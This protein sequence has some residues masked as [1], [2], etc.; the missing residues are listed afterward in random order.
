M[1]LPKK[2]WYINQSQSE[3]ICNRHLSL[4]KKSFQP[5]LLAINHFSH[6]R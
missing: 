5:S 4:N 6:R 3:N 2:T 1:V